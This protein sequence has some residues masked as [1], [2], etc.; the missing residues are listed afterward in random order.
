MKFGIIDLHITLM[1]R[2]EFR[3]N[4]LCLTVLKDVN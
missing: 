1:S 3:E 2:R 4:R